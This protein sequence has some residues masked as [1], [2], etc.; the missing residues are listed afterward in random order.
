MKG[1]SLEKLVD[2]SVRRV[3]E[4]KFKLGL[5]KDPYR[6]CNVETEKKTVLS[7]EIQNAAL[8]RC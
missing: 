8:E 4:A 2:E 3:I 5:F 6:Y 1:K 7:S